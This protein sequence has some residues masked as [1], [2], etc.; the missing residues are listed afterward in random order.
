MIDLRPYLPQSTGDEPLPFRYVNQ[1][2]DWRF[3]GPIGLLF[4][5]IQRASLVYST[6]QAKWLVQVPLGAD[7]YV[8]VQWPP[9]FSLRVR[10]SNGLYARIRIGWRYDHNVGDGKNLPREPVHD[11]PGAYFLD[12]WITRNAK[13]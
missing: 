6:Y 1:G 7:G 10:R 11:P 8:G 4:G 5:G 9:L 3:G 2:T 12:W 13:E